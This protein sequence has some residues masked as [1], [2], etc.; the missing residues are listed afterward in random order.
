VTVSARTRAVALSIAGIIAP[1]WFITLVIIQGILQPDYSHITMPVSALAAWPAGWMQRLNFYGVAALMAI[2]AIGVHR[3]VLPTRY[4]TLGIVLLFA[5]CL[6]LVIAGLFPWIMVNGVPTE[7]K[8]HAVGAILSFSGASTGFIALSRR[9]RADARWRSVAPYV[10]TT[11]LVMLILFIVLGAFAIEDGTPLHPW[12]GL[13]QRVV[14][15]L[16]FACTTTIAFRALRIGSNA[17]SA[18]GLTRS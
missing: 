14:V 17:S 4:G 18:S 7:T 16:W 15:V 13:L 3:T 9:M 2:F 12:A 5:S 8:P 10:L 11:G 1:I 6:G